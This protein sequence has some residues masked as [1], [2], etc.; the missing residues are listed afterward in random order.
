LSLGRS[1]E[2]SNIVKSTSTAL[3]DIFPIKGKKHTLVLKKHWLDGG[4]AP[5]NFEEQ[6]KIKMKSGT[7]AKNVYGSFELIDNKSGKVIDRSEKV[8]LMSIPIKTH[9]DSYIVKGNEYQVKQQLRRMPGVYTFAK[10]TG[11][12]FK[13]QFNLSKGKNFDITFDPAERKFNVAVGNTKRPLYSLL[14][15]M[16]ASEDEM[17]K[18][19][20]REILSAN[21]SKNLAVDAKRLSKAFKLES[22]TPQAFQSYFKGTSLSPDITSITLGQRHDKVSPK[23]LME[24]AKKLKDVYRGEAEADDVESLLFKDLHSTEDYLKERLLKNIRPIQN[25]IR[26]KLDKKDKVS[27]ILRLGDLNEKIET[28]FTT[29]ER[30]NPSE[31]YNPAHFLGSATRATLMGPGGITNVQQLKPSMRDA[32]PSHLGF[33]DPIQTP[34]SEKT[35]AVLNIPIAARKQGNRIVTPVLNV[36]TMRK[37]M[38]SPQDLFD[39]KVAFPDQGDIEGGNRLKKWL[40]PKIKVKYQN[41]IISVPRGEV[42]YILPSTKNL[43]SLSSN[44]IPFI[45]NNQSNRAVFAAKQIEQAVPLKYREAPL[46]QPLAN[47][48]GQSFAEAI[49]S[50]YSHKSPAA[51]KVIKVTNKEIYVKSGKTTHRVALYNNFPLNQSTLMHSTPI[52]RKGQTVTKGQLLAD[53]NYTKNGT[54]ALGTNLKTAYMVWPGA[55]FEDGVAISETGAKKLTSEHMYRYEQNKEE[56]RKFSKASFLAHFPQKISADNKEKLD[57][58]GIVRVGQKVMPGDVLVASLKQRP[59]TPE[60]SVLFKRHRGM[61]KP[62][63]NDSISYEN[64]VPGVVTDVIK[65]NKGYK[66]LVKTEEPARV[67]DK[68]SGLHGNKGI[69]AEIIPDNMAPRTK[70]NKAIDLI[71]NP[72]GVIS[73]INVG[74]I[75]ESAAGKLAKAKGSAYKFTNFDHINHRDKISGD[76]AKLGLSDKES[77]FDASGK[78]LGNI[79]V[80]YPHILKLFKTGQSTLSARSVGEGYD[81]YNMQPLRGGK[82]GAKRVGPLTQYALLSHDARNILREMGTQ[83]SENNPEFWDAIRTGKTPPTPK[84]SFAYEKFLSMLQSAGVDVK[85]EGTQIQLLPQTDRQVMAMSKGAIEKPEFVNSKDLS[86]RKGGYYDPRLAGGMQ[87]NHFNHIELSETLPNPVFETPIK[88]LLGLTAIQYKGLIEGTYSISSS[89]RVIKGSDGVTG[90]AAFSKLLGAL[91]VKKE[92]AKYEKDAKGTGERKKNAYKN[93]RYLRTLEEN[94]LTPSDAYLKSKI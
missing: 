47:K 94:N 5:E 89:G 70:D 19:W 79:H 10:E 60:E 68:I 23:L 50:Q 22:D 34:E 3:K 72:H 75:Y 15:T 44:L 41:K 32:H 33:L 92:I 13:T 6:K 71:L 87:G 90:G 37:E 26:R 2:F 40:F 67:G 69:I 43:F 64:D 93:L 46:V 14:K 17:A 88:K 53:T 84:S 57:V 85:K 9:R 29:D 76:L 25:K 61:S 42:D 82:K 59:L 56:G 36:K 38:K 65:T 83:K 11:G 49:G 52:V 12:D 1:E 66:V 18:A 45:K 54:L 58:N 39:K 91:D 81:K 74:Q 28:F 51:G 77:V 31:Q 63:Q 27:D 20:G 73:R 80:G 35:G 7:Y 8:K 86:P 55:T 16:G 4:D 78:R 30:S 62:M 48:S 24:A 21:K